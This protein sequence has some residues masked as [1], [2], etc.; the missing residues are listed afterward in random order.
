MTSSKGSAT[1][2]EARRFPIGRDPLLSARVRTELIETL[3]AKTGF[4]PAQA[5]RELESRDVRAEFLAL[6]GGLGLA[7]DNL[8]DVLA[9]HLIAMWATVH[10][11]ELPT[12][13]VGAAI[14]RQFA[15]QIATSAEAADPAKRQLMGEALLYECVLTVEALVAART[16]RDAAQLARMAESAQR[17]FLAQR[18]INLRKTELTARGM[19]RR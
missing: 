2:F 13:E 10:G 5:A 16:S 18:S 6:F 11:G 17:N 1:D 4:D 9:A 3:V 19:Q 12:A 14:A 7:P 8:P 15:G